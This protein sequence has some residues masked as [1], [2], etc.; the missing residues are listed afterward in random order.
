MPNKSREH[1]VVVPLPNTLE[2][3]YVYYE[4]VFINNTEN[5]VNAT[6]DD[7]KSIPILDKLSDYKMAVF[8]FDVGAATT[9]MF[10]VRGNKPVCS[11][12]LT[13]EPDNLISIKTVFPTLPTLEIFNVGKF[14]DNIDGG[15]N[16]TIALAFNDIKA[17]YDAIHGAGSWAA[18][19]NLAQSPPGIIY[20]AS[21]KLFS[22]VSPDK[23]VD[24]S[25]DA[26]SLY[27]SYDI[28]PLFLGLYIS[29]VPQIAAL[30][31]DAWYRYGVVPTFRNGNLSGGYYTMTQEFSSTAKWYT[32]NKIVIT[33]P[34]L[35][36]RKTFVGFLTADDSG[37]TNNKQLETVMDI[38]VN[39][40]NDNEN[41]PST[42]I[43]YIPQNL[44]WIDCLGTKAL[45]RIILSLGFLDEV[46]N[47]YPAQVIP[48][49]SFSVTLVFAKKIS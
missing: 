38:S 25:V 9:P 28:V 24:T 40:S 42:N 43:T 13:Y 1:D 7:S 22:L 27:L 36:T 6:I 10:I 49:S 4:A 31:R 34:G 33:S 14:L 21:N 37:F 19:I 23:N 29:S 16:E 5:I 8:R 20:D 41:N 45:D 46:G 15:L 11:V 47:L 30:P 12:A 26:V 39:L 17:Q 3:E 18:N 35:G 2:T 44:R 32:V 48:G